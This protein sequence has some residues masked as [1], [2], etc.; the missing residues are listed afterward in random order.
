MDQGLL[1]MLLAVFAPLIAPYDPKNPL[2]GPGEPGRRAAPCVHVFYGMPESI[3]PIP[4]LGAW[5]CP[6]DQMETYLGTDNNSRDLFSRVVYGGRLSIPI[7]PV[8]VWQCR[9]TAPL[10]D[11]LRAQ[12]H[13]PLLHRRTGLTID[14][15]FSATKMRWL[16]DQLDRGQERAEAGEICFGNT[17]AWVA[18]NLTGGAHV[19]D[20]SNASRTQLLALEAVEAVALEVDPLGVGHQRLVDVVGREGGGDAEIGVHR[21]FAVGRDR[22][23]YIVAVAGQSKEGLQVAA[24]IASRVI[25]LPIYPDLTDKQVDCVLSAVV[26]EK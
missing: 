21:A 5:G 13:E 23:G 2:N 3:G 8:V 17:D 18:W 24:S 16:L 19:T 26:T 4:F 25:C 9:R 12:G 20:S 7:G 6:E 22:R 14:P 1:L 10:C 15:L 11:A